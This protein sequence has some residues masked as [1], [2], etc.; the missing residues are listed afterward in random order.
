MHVTSQ[1]NLRIL[2]V[3]ESSRVSEH[4]LGDP[5]YVLFSKRPNHSEVT[6]SRSVMACL[7]SRNG[8]G[9]R[10]R[11]REFAGRELFPRL[12]GTLIS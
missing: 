3:S 5:T 12:I 4:G 6:E 2:R 9:L 7:C 11:T 8:D 10:R 1:R